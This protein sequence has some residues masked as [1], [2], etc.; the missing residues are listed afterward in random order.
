M[1]TGAASDADET[2]V[3]DEASAGEAEF[4]AIGFMR[5]DLCVDAAAEDSSMCALDDFSTAD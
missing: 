2:A 1:A 5:G 3:A 4:E